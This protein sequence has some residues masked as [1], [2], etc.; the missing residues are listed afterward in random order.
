[1][2]SG[3]R[4]NCFACCD[5]PLRRRNARRDA[6]DACST[7]SLLCGRTPPK[8]GTA[9]RREIR[10]K[11]TSSNSPPHFLAWTRRQSPERQSRC[12]HDGGLTL[13]AQGGIRSSRAVL[14]R[15]GIACLSAPARL[16]AAWTNCFSRRSRYRK[17]KRRPNV[18]GAW[19]NGRASATIQPSVSGRRTWRR[20]EKQQRRKKL[21]L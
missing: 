12:R 15:R 9:S 18:Q 11:R 10:P 1:M 5:H 3:R 8:A 17:T 7:P 13:I 21:V 2:F 19:R 20:K 16:L 6:D 14:T 4:T